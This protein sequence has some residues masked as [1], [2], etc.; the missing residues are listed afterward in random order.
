MPGKNLVAVSLL[1]LLALGLAGCSEAGSKADAELGT[2]P[3]K[4][5]ANEIPITLNDIRAYI[6]ILPE[7]APVEYTDGREAARIYKRHGLSRLRYKYLQA[8]ITLCAGLNAGAS[9]DLSKLPASLKPNDSELSLIDD[10]WDAIDA[11]Q[12]AYSQ[13]LVR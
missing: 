6:A 9:H 8:K 7:I 12:Q 2:V 5:V 11:A 3:L 1:C 10:H 13:K 4:A